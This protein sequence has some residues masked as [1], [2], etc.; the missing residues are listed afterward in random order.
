[1]SQ[2]PEISDRALNRA[3]LARQGLL[4]PLPS[5]AV[6]DRVRHVGSLQAQHPEWPPIA[7]W[8]RSG[9]AP[10]SL[11]GALEQRSIVRAALMRITVHIVAAD[12]FW[13]MSTLVQPLRLQQ[14][15]AFFKADAVDS[16]LARQLRRGHAA[17]RAALAERPLRI[18]DMDA[19]MRT[20]VPKLAAH[21]H[22][23][24]WRHIA[25]TMPLVH[26]PFDGEG[27]GRSRYALAES[28]IGQPPVG[29]DEAAALR[30]VTERYLAAFG[31][32][33]VE[34]LMAWAGRRGTA[35]RW[36]SA[37]AELGDR[38]VRL[39]S[40][41]GRELLDLAD[42]PR[43]DE[44]TEAPP[45]LL[46]RWDSLLL[47]HAPGRRGR[48]IADADLPAVY[49]RNADVLPSFL[50]DGRVAGTWDLDA[51]TARIGLHPFRSLERRTREPLVDEAERL[52]GRVAPGL[53]PTVDVA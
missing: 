39:A 2:H 5:C 44:A 48:F 18:R 1:M 53:P 28:W 46:A 15:R 16:P 33:S 26:V 10:G 47:S 3:T 50:V 49:T 31:P 29:L 52:L 41:D 12:D 37:I 13:P 8:S 23:I 17:V 20:E 35:R 27:Y 30:H 21:P 36:Q 42:A 4:E 51:A 38:V 40:A 11:R 34:D 43:P 32:A 9:S 45:R 6:A 25:A 22:R 7:L 19:I 24:Y 14:F